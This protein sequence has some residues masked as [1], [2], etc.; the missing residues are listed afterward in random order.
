MRNSTR[1]ILAH[2]NANVGKEHTRTAMLLSMVV[3]SDT[4]ASPEDLNIALTNILQFIRNT[5]TWNRSWGG[6]EQDFYVK[7]CVAK[8]AL[9][10]LLETSDFVP[11]VTNHPRKIC[12]ET[13]SLAVVKDTFEGCAVMPTLVD[14]YLRVQFVKTQMLLDQQA[15]AVGMQGVS[16]A[17]DPQLLKRSVLQPLILNEILH[18]EQN[19]GVNA[20]TAEQIDLQ[21]SSMNK[22]QLVQFV[23]KHRVQQGTYLGMKFIHRLQVNTAHPLSVTFSTAKVGHTKLT[24][25]FCVTKCKVVHTSNQATQEVVVY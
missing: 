11:V 23:I 12:F 2:P 19:N 20:R 13:N 25:R 14:P 17:R 21:L 1:Q 8:F 24:V 16:V 10:P 18:F 4:V 5:M 9:I 6:V 7:K 15:V 22:A 3:S